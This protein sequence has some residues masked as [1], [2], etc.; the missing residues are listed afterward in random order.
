MLERLF[1]HLN[2]SS[3]RFLRF[4][5]RSAF[6]AASETAWWN[7]S[8]AE[9]ARP[10]CAGL[11]EQGGGVRW[12]LEYGEGKQERQRK[13]EKEKKKQKGKPLGVR[14]SEWAWACVPGARHIGSKGSPL[15]WR[16]TVNIG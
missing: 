11:R 8:G 6:L 12:C 4:K 7:S 10:A 9:L 1:S 3:V 5:S 15:R 16:L 13:E 2:I 14:A